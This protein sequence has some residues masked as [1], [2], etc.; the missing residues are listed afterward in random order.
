MITNQENNQGFMN[1]LSQ[2][3]QGCQTTS[4][5]FFQPWVMPQM[6]FQPPQVSF[7]PS[8]YS[9]TNF[10]QFYGPP[11]PTHVDT[12]VFTASSPESA[13]SLSEDSEMSDTSA[14]GANNPELINPANCTI[15]SSDEYMDSET[16]KDLSSVYNYLQS[17]LYPLNFSKTDKNAIHK[18]AK[19]FELRDNILYYVHSKDISGK[20]VY[21]P[22]KNSEKSLSSVT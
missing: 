19:H 2:N 21:C 17:N 18:R 20:K 22:K 8:V 3:Y 6:S 4:S 12:P 14:K 5:Q 15:D 10:T 11:N 7:Q 1:Q 16:E 13:Q 9:Y